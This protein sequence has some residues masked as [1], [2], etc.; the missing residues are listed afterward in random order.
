M[1]YLFFLFVCLFCFFCWI[2]M[3]KHRSRTRPS[4]NTLLDMSLKK[5][6]CFLTSL[7]K[8][9]SPLQLFSNFL[10]V[11]QPLKSTNR[12]ASLFPFKLLTKTSFSCCCV[13]DNDRYNVLCENWG[14]RNVPKWSLEMKVFEEFLE[15][16]AVEYQLAFSSL[17]TQVSLILLSQFHPWTNWRQQNKGLLFLDE[18]TSGLDSNTANNIMGMLLALSRRGRTV[19]CTIHQPRS[20]IFYMF[21]HIM[22]LSKVRA[23]K[24]REKKK[25]HWFR[26]FFFFSLSLQRNWVKKKKKKL[27]TTGRSSLLWISWWDDSIF[28]R[29]WLSVSTIHQ[30]H[31]LCQ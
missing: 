7:S 25:I 14:W 23:F 22:L 4:S 8:R 13:H 15:V 29:D 20:A 6:L 27:I 2:E 31:W 11:S 30:P 17:S 26:M 9:L 21:D 24:K 10:P 5:I 1:C 16:N 12:S 28:R 18:P 3:L 19:M